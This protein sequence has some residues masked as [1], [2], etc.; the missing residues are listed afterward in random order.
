MA[1]GAIILGLIIIMFGIW[2]GI[3]TNSWIGSL[4]F[5]IIGTALIIFWKEETKIEERE[6][7]KPKKTRK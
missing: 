7:L 1:K 2:F 6:D 5:I 3:K 4:A